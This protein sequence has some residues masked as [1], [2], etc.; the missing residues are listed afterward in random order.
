MCHVSMSSL[1]LRCRIVCVGFDDFVSFFAVFHVVLVVGRSALAQS[2]IVLE[3]YP[4]PVLPMW[5]FVRLS[6]FHFLD[7]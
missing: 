7:F 2:E 5:L 3:I 1:L 4:I 6:C